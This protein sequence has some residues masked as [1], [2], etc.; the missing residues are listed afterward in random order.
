MHQNKILMN[1]KKDFQPKKTQC[2]ILFQKKVALC[3]QPMYTTYRIG[4]LQ[5]SAR[6]HK[7]IALCTQQAYTTYGIRKL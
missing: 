2:R 1:Q 3:T 4:K 7:K 6:N 5:N